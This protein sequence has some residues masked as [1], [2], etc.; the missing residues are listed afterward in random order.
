MNYSRP[1]AWLKLTWVATALICFARPSIAAPPDTDQEKIVAA[2]RAM[3]VALTNDDL[4]G[5]RAVTSPEFYAFDGGSRMTGDELMG[6]AQNAH[7]AGKIYIWQVTEPQVH[8]DGRTAW[9]TYINRGSLQDAAGMKRLRWLESAVLHK[10]HGRWRI[11]FLH[12]T[13]AKE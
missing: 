7:A 6:F 1:V 10:E 9:M 12:S 13:R 5:F 3:F 2:V 8:I 11:H 4:A